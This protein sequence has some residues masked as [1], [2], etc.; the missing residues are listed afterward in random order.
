M[1]FRCE[2]LREHGVVLIPPSSREFA[3][4]LADIQQRLD[5]PVEGSPPK[6]P[7]RQ[8]QIHEEDRRKSAILVNISET[9]IAGVQ[10]VWRYK[11]AAWRGFDGTPPEYTHSYGPGASNSVLLPFGWQAKQ[12][13]LYGYWHVILPGSKRYMSPDGQ[14]LGDNSDVRPPIGEEIWQGGIMGSGGSSRRDAAADLESITLSLDGVFFTDGSFAGPNKHKL[15]EQVTGNA[16]AHQQVLGIAEEGLQRGDTPAHILAK[17][18]TV[19]PA[20]DRPPMPRPPSGMGCE[21]EYRL[22]ALQQIGFR[23]SHQQSRL[24]DEETLQTILGWAD[25]KVPKFRKLPHIR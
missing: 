7:G 9:G 3:G 23:I 15:F 11:E 13:A 4:L 16:A 6:F 20:A 21:D 2:D 17:I 19:A 25:A 1:E 8:T 10:Q 12:L 18:R 14:L 22:R 5:H 24:G